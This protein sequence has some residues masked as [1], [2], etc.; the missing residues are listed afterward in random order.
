M[1]VWKRSRFSVS[2]KNYA[3]N[4]NE[5]DD[6]R[7]ER[8]IELFQFK[9]T[10]IKDVQSNNLPKVDINSFDVTDEQVTK[11]VNEKI[12]KEKE[13]REEKGKKAANS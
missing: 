11:E 3:T 13:N 4:C 12:K 2:P 8:A 1:D 5:H 7:I 9:R 6:K 10:K